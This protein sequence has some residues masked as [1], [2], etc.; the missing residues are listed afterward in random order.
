MKKIIRLVGL[1]LILVVISTSFSGCYLWTGVEANQVALKLK[2]GSVESV[3]GAGRYTSFRWWNKI[4]KIEISAKTSTWE[5]PDLWTA[6]K[7]PI[8]FSITVTYARK[9]DAKS[10]TEMWSAY[11]A[12][13]KD[14]EALQKLVLTRIPRVAKQITTSM[15]LDAMLGIASSEEELIKDADEAVATIQGRELLQQKM[16]ELLQTE[17]DEFYVTVLDIGVNNIAPDET[18]A[19][20]LKEKAV[21]KIAI[22]VAAQKTLQ[23]EEQIKQEKAQTI[24][25]LEIAN[26]KKLVLTEENKVYILN[27]QAFQLEKLR[28]LKDVIGDK[29]KVYFVP[30]GSDLTLFLQGSNEDF[31]PVPVQ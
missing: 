13:A 6:D 25:D 15:T 4:Q 30:Q 26:R 5:D 7:Q 29:S 24:V 1:L 12:E 8:A 19:D 10:T 28:L 18:Y 21:N 3:V 9:S 2:E 20:K 16:M 14:D 11:N 27:P 23:L 17:L 31:V 22:E